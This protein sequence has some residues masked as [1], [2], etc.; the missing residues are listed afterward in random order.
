MLIIILETKKEP[1]LLLP[2]VENKV[3]SFHFH[4]WLCLFW[5]TVQSWINLWWQQKRWLEVALHIN[6]ASIL[7]GSEFLKP[8]SKFSD[9]VPFIKSSCQWDFQWKHWKITNISCLSK[10]FSECMSNAGLVCTNDA[11]FFLDRAF[12]EGLT[13]S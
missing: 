3:H 7:D 8:T 1:C 10:Y 2:W 11:D 5:D 4:C 13:V 9:S 6:Y 12:T